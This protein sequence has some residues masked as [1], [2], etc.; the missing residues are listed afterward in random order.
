MADWDRF[1][2]SGITGAALDDGV[3]A[4][5]LSRAGEAAAWLGQATVV[6]MQGRAVDQET[7]CPGGY[8]RDALRVL[9]HAVAAAEAEPRE[10][11]VCGPCGLAYHS[12]VLCL[13]C[14]VMTAV[15]R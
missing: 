14:G 13:L 8:H 2:T 7:P 1:G 5:G 9:T 3:T 15:R 6:D 11:W 12:P 4:E 10:V